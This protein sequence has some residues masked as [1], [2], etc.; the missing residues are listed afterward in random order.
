MG[1]SLSDF[2]PTS[3][4]SKFGG[5]IRTGMN[6]VAPGSSEVLQMAS[7]TYHSAADKPKD[8]GRTTSAT[9]AAQAQPTT[10]MAAYSVKQAPGGVPTWAWVTGGVALAGVAVLI[11]VKGGPKWALAGVGVVGVG[12]VLLW[13]KKASAATATAI[14]AGQ[15]A[16]AGQVLQ[17]AMRGETTFTPA[18][19]AA[20]KKEVSKK[21]VGN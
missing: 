7:D 2:D 13:S 11:A 18:Q 19:V 14:K 12:G 5:A 17:S 21:K 16:T 6:I 4:T 15:Q 3:S 8:K 10:F 9:S 1:L 20:A